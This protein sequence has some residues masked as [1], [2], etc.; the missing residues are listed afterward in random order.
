MVWVSL[1]GAM[2]AT[3][4]GDAE[5]KANRAGQKELPSGPGLAAQF[6]G[7]AGLKGNAEVIFADDFESGNLGAAAAYS[8]ILVVIVALA[9]GLIRL[10]LR[11][12][13]GRFGGNMLHF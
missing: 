5:G 1:L 13:Y 7:D 11:A 2:V 12:K 8:V 3:A 9:I 4:G 6:P 10:I